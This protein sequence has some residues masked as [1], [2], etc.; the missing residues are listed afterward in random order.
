MRAASRCCS[1]S[2]TTTSARKE[3]SCRSTRRIL[4]RPA[5]HARGATRS[6]DGQRA[7]PVRDFFI[8]NALY[9]LEEFHLDGLRSTPCT[10]SRTIAR[11]DLLDELAR[12]S[13]RGSRRPLHLILENEDNDPGR[14]TRT[15]TARRRSTPRNGTTTSIMFCMSPP[16]M[17]EQATTPPTAQHDLLGKAIAEGF[18]YQGE[19]M[20]YRRAARGQPSARLP[21]DAF[22]VLHPEP[23]PDRQS[24]VWRTAG[25]LAAPEAMRALAGIYLLA[26]QI[27]M[28]FMGEE[29]GACRRSSFSATS[30]ES[31]RRP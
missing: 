12:A 28:L 13:P 26:P 11:H 6:T 27:P 7:E 24:R 18:A 19:M 10:R 15:V 2:S 4:H 8:E 25:T 3:I 5:Q 22:V 29:W 14:L 20:P 23:R 30:R 9:W 16:P 31:W 1:T 17:R 21:P